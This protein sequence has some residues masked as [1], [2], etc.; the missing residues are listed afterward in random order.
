MRVFF[1]CA[2]SSPSPPKHNSKPC[3]GG[4]AKRAFIAGTK[5]L[6]QAEPA[7]PEEPIL[8]PAMAITQTV[9]RS[10]LSGSVH[11]LNSFHDNQI[12]PAMVAAAESVAEIER[13]L[14][15]I[16]DLKIRAHQIQ[17][18]NMQVEIANLRSQLKHYDTCHRE[19]RS[20]SCSMDVNHSRLFSI[21]QQVK[22]VSE[23]MQEHRIR[24]V[25]VERAL[26]SFVFHSVD[27]LVDVETGMRALEAPRQP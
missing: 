4:P 6:L 5:P 24:I 12:S 17:I 11:L 8:T 20:T 15:A 2:M 16:T 27:Q 1:V 10:L 26:G 18:Q 19:L 9:L 13:E 25:A 21:E 3:P 23:A 22:Q 14:N 7:K